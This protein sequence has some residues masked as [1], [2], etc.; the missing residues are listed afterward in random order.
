LNPVPVHHRACSE[1]SNL[2]YGQHAPHVVQRILRHSS[3][4]ITAEVYGHLD[5][6]DIGAALGSLSF[7]PKADEQ[8]AEVIPLA[9][10]DNFGAP[11]VRNA[12]QGGKETAATA[13]I[14]EGT[15][16]VICP[17]ALQDSNLGPIACP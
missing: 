12:G 6:D 1:A 17:W 14:V 10:G 7:V 3:P 13:S 9:I 15:R 2:N 4:T 16:E 8:S 11:V 5:L